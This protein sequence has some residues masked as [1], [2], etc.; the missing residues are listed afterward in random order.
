MS[1]NQKIIYTSKDI[2][3]ITDVSLL[4]EIIS[5][6][7]EN[8]KIR[9]NCLFQLRTISSIEAIKAL[10]FTLLSEPSSDLLRHEICYAFG[11]MIG[12]NEN[13]TEIEDF[14]YKEVFNKPSKWAS[15]VLHEAAEALGNISNEN[16]IRLLEKFLSYDDEIIKETCELAI[17][18]L[19]WMR[20]TNNGETEGFDLS[21]KEYITNDPSPPFNYKKNEK[22]KNIEYLNQVLQTGSLFERNRVIFTLRNIGSSEAISLLCSCFSTNFSAL[23]KHEVAF[24]LGQMAEVASEALSK[25]EEVLQDENENPI[26]RHETALTLGE[27]SKGKELLKKYSTHHDQ[28]IAESCIIA[29]E[30]VDYWKE[31]HN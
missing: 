14:L 9:M 7:N 27:I 6:S 28:L 16:N 19:K 12:T 20:D 29:E 1:S 17:E 21:E 5:N 25:L 11:Q 18:N 3:N 2:D 24:I 10:E 23:F 15:I 30:F 22:Y 31:M 13:K 4:K 8:I 26:V